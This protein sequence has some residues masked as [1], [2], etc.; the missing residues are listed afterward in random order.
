MMSTHVFASPIEQCLSQI[1]S[2]HHII[3][4]EDLILSCFNKYK[5]SIGSNLCF[6][7]ANKSKKIK[8]SFSLTEKIK[9]ICFYESS[10]FQNISSCLLK[11]K[12]FKNAE[13]RD[14]SVFD[15]YRQFQSSL[16][17]QQCFTV[18][19]YLTYPSKKEYMQQ[20]CYN[21]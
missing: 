5:D 9:S 13:S 10:I 19:P 4:S 8:K 17:Q 14:E 15:C 1:S 16:T 12:E 2:K 3:E 21:N 11:T 6:Q 7:L 18:V 20:Q